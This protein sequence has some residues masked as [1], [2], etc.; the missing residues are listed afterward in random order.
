MS[1]QGEKML[2]AMAEAVGDKT[3]WRTPDPVWSPGR[4]QGNTAESALE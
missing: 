3:L 4:G 1:G 2:H